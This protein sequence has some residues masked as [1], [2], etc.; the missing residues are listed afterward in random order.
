MEP[1]LSCQPDIRSLH[2]HP[3]V[4]LMVACPSVDLAPLLVTVWVQG[5]SMLLISLDFQSAEK[6]KLAFFRKSSRTKSRT[7]MYLSHFDSISFVPLLLRSILYWIG[8][9]HLSCTQRS[10]WE[11]G[12][13]DF[14]EFA[15]I[16]LLQCLHL[17]LLKCWILVFQW[18]FSQSTRVALVCF[19]FSNTKLASVSSVKP[20]H[21]L[22]GFN[23][24]DMNVWLFQ[25]FLCFVSCS[26][27]WWECGSCPGLHIAFGPDGVV[28]PASPS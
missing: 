17:L 25:L 12:V 26:K 15:G 9:W 18:S 8:I 13:V 6:Y 27:G 5:I 20:S 23:H 3:E 16:A 10:V 7:K 22:S 11:W 24:M 14:V 28:P 2:L 1:N 4:P 19:A 21:W